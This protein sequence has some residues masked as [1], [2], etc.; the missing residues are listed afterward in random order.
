VPSSS[1]SSKALGP[2]LLA[3]ESYFEL[4]A[5]A[6]ERGLGVTPSARKGPHALNFKILTVTR[7]VSRAPRL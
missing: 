4:A 7:L 6:L 1:R 2:A 5:S 3:A